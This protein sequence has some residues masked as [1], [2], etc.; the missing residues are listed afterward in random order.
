LIFL[1]RNASS[2]VYENALLTVEIPGTLGFEQDGEDEGTGG[3]VKVVTRCRGSR[4]VARQV[5]TEPPLRINVG[6]QKLTVW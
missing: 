5:R 2:P 4:F 1:V 6:G 3:V